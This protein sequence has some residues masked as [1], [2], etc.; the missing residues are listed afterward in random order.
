VILLDTSVLS[1]VLRRRQAGAPERA[2]SDR[3]EK[4]LKAGERVAVPGVVLQELLSGIREPSVFEK[5][6]NVLLRSYPLMTA[7]VGDHVLAADVVNRCKRKGV[8]ASSIDALI[9]ALALNARARL[10][11]TDEDFKHI[12]RIVDLRL[13]EE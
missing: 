8:A 7:S 5:V 2:L 13:L 11:T 12:S 9:T 3:L 6:K 4:I 10:F 1:T